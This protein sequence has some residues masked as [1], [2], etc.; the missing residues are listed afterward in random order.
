MYHMSSFRFAALSAVE[1]QG[2]NQK[3][4]HTVL[5]CLVPL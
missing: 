1:N 2:P 5:V 3:P 4:D